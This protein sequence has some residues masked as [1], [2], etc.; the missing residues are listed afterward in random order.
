MMLS[1]NGGPASPTAD[2]WVNYAIPVI[3]GLMYRDSVEVD[4]LKHPFRVETLGVVADSAGAGRFRGAPAREVT[5]AALENPV[6]V[7][8]PCDGQFAPPRGVNGGHDGTPGSTHLIDHNGGIAKLPNLVNM[9][10]RKDQ[11]LRG[12]DSSGGGYGDPLTRDPLRVLTDVL[13]GYESLGKARDVYGVVFTGRI[14]DDSLE[15]DVA[16]T[17][18]RRADLAGQPRVRGLEPAAE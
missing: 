3:A 12:R 6:Q 10:I 15:V 9:Q 7:V 4:E 17:Q 11:R 14:E 16:A 1:T 5:Y 13:E 8:I 18:A 2:G